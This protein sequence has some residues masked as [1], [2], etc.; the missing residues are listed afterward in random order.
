[1]LRKLI[2]K[3]KKRIHTVIQTGLIDVLINQLIPETENGCQAL[4][5]LREICRVEA[6]PQLKTRI[7]IIDHIINMSMSENLRMKNAALQLLMFLPLYD[8]SYC[9]PIAKCPSFLA[10]LDLLTEPISNVKVQEKVMILLCKIFDSDY[11]AYS[12][13][14]EL[15]HALNIFE[16]IEQMP[17]EDTEIFYLRLCF[18]NNLSNHDVTIRYKIVESGFIDNTLPHILTEQFIYKTKQAMERLVIKL[19]NLRDPNVIRHL[20]SINCIELLKFGLQELTGSSLLSCVQ[21]LNTILHVGSKNGIQEF[22]DSI[23]EDED[24]VELLQS[25]L[26]AEPKHLVTTAKRS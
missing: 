1:M 2:R 5:L 15:F 19:I 9:L 23:Y 8:E 13:N 6:L 26:I 12:L 24:I 7:Y 17:I 25:I 10:I 3:R 18:F 21:S 20:L 14:E 22:I 16:R 11:L 4:M